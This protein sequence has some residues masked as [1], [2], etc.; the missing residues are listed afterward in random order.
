[1]RGN[2][3]KFFVCPLSR[4]AFCSWTLPFQKFLVFSKGCWFFCKEIWRTMV[5]GINN[6]NFDHYHREECHPWCSKTLLEATT[7]RRRIK[8][9]HVSCI[10]AT[11]CNVLPDSSRVWT[12]GQGSFME[13][14]GTWWRGIW[15]WGQVHRTERY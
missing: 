6:Y 5:A 12:W 9:I 15:M 8:S 7:T 2:G 4:F 14:H 1:M 11:V 13:V 10:I 3:R